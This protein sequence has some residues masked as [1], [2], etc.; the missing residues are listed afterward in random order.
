VILLLFELNIDQ[1]LVCNDLG[2]LGS[3]KLIKCGENWNLVSPAACSFLQLMLMLVMRITTVYGNSSTVL[4][5]DQ[6][7]VECY[8]LQR[9]IIILI[10]RSFSRHLCNIMHTDAHQKSH[11]TFDIHTV[12]K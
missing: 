11:Q 5:K 4:P 10:I 9:V 3:A 8:L 1:W 2:L 12:R 6:F 7:C